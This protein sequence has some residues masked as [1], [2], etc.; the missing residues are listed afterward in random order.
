MGCKSY[1][2]EK[3]R[4]EEDGSF[5]GKGVLQGAEGQRPGVLSALSHQVECG[6]PGIHAWMTW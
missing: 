1:S 4:K 2:N 5:P 6:D 3:N